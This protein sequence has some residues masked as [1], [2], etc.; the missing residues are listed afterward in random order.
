MMISELFASSDMKFNHYP[1]CS[2]YF[3]TNDHEY[4][5]QK[6]NG[7]YKHIKIRLR[8]YTRN[9]FDNGPLWLETKIK[10]EDRLTK[11]RQVI[12]GKARNYLSPENWSLMEREDL[13]RERAIYKLRPSCFIYYEREAFESFFDENKIRITFDENISSYSLLGK[14]ESRKR[15]F[16]HKDD[17]S[18]LMEI[19]L[20]KDQYPN[21]LKDLLQ[22]FSL[23]RVYF[24]KYAEG[25]S[26]IKD[27]L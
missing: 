22:Q 21:F 15:V 12:H 8:K 6:I 11:K 23:K 13:L 4:F 5:F 25:L 27:I 14:F 19:K 16:S 3:D 24:S 1:V 10:I 26:I 2:L 9:F 20:S 7:E 17:K 18:I